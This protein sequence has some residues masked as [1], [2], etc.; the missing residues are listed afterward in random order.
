MSPLRERLG[1]RLLIAELLIIVTAALVGV[2]RALRPGWVVG[3]GVDAYGTLWF[4]WWV[5][6]CILALRDPSFTDLFFY[7]LGKDL[8][9]HTGNNFLDALFAAPFRWILGELDYQ[10]WFVAAMMIAN[11]LSFRVLA[12]YV[13]RHRGAA[14]VAAVAWEMNPYVLFEITCGRLTQAFLPFLPLAFYHLLRCEEPDARWR[15]PLLAGLFTALQAW[16]YWFMGWFMAFAFVWIAAVGLSRSPDRR[17]LAL[18]YLL[19]G[20]ACAAAV[21]P[22]ALA[23]VS[24]ARE[25]EVPGLV[26]GGLS[27]EALLSPPPPQRNNVST[28]LYGLLVVEGSGVPMISSLSYGLPLLAWL[29]LGPGRLRWAPALG[30]LLAFAVGPVLGPPGGE[31]PMPHYMLAYY[32]LPFFERLWFPYRMASVAFVPVALGFGFLALRALG[33]WPSAGRAMVPAAAAVALLSGLERSRFDVYP[34]AARD[35]RPPE[36]VDWI[37]REGGAVIDMPFGIYKASVIWQTFNRA[38]TFGGMGENAV[39]L[40]P[41][42]MRRHLR[43]S[44]IHALITACRK[45]REAISYRAP[46]RAMIEA[47]GFRWVVL[48]RELIVERGAPPGAGRRSP[49]EPVLKMIEVLGE[50]SAVEGPHLVWDLTGEASPPPGLEPT[51]AKIRAPI[52]VGDP[53]PAYEIALERAGRSGRGRGAER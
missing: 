9:A 1:D 10:P 43:N 20:L 50:P 33:R 44:F 7:P 18:R 4:Y 26:E 52:V 16:T 36:L 8:F 5:Q 22:G 3:D 46:Q 12:R 19:A 42:G 32:V 45:P 51:E 35:Q 23:M 28:T 41:E 31:I 14:L 53:R 24:L 48:H 11:A 29:I 17:R 15:H 38:P 40:W 13:L 49:I 34:F 47:E 39:M 6:D 2:G 25:G 30:V 27:L 37:G 21:A